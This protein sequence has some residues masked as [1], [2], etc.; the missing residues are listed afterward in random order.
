VTPYARG[1]RNQR[2]EQR[3]QLE[4]ALEKIAK[5]C[6]RRDSK[7]QALI[8]TNKLLRRI[9]DY[10]SSRARFRHYGHFVGLQRTERARREGWLCYVIRLTHNERNIGRRRGLVAGTKSSAIA[11]A[12]TIVHVDQL[13]PVEQRAYKI[14]RGGRR[15]KEGTKHPIEKR[16]VELAEAV[17]TEWFTALPR[18]HRKEQSFGMLKPLLTIS[19]VVS[20]A[21]PVIEEFARE[22]ISARNL[23]S[24]ALEHTIRF[25][26]KVGWIAREA[27]FSRDKVISKKSLLVALSRM[28]RQGRTD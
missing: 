10:R 18:K 5:G 17:E 3:R 28:R 15:P 23:G 26:L 12:T 16:A 4:A 6:G 9:D 24:D 14:L 20:I 25:C 8:T 21:A 11:D 7:L 22:K 19:E 27:S 1:E 2:A 13:N